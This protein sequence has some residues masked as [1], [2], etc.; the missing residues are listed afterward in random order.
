MQPPLCYRSMGSLYVPGKLPTYPSP[1]PTFCPKS[2][3]TTALMLAKGMGRWAVSQYGNR[4]SRNR[5]ALRLSCGIRDPGLWNP[6]LGSKNPKSR[7][8]QCGIQ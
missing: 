6:G 2:E 4:D 1:K 3:V 5:K 7:Q 8:M